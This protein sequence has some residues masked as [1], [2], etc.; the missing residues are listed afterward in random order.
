MTQEMNVQTAPPALLVARQW[1]TLMVVGIITIAVGAAVLA[2]PSETLTV[3]SVL[4]GLQ[5]LVFGLFRLISAFA[6]DVASP[7]LLGFIGVLGILGGVVVLR[8]PNETV[9]VLATILG[10]FWIISGVIDVIDALA[11]SSASGRVWRA[12]GGLL[13]IGAGAVIVAWP[14]PTVTVIAWIAGFYLIVF[15][16]FLCASAFSMRS[17]ASD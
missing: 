17:L 14:S 12:F 16:L 8:N 6:S 5:L 2:W 13:S 15:G 1:P 3:L 7:G 9:A 10:A 11:N 4:L